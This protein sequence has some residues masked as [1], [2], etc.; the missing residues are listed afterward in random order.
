[1]GILHKDLTR[2]SRDA[3]K[4]RKEILSITDN[5]VSAQTS[6]DLIARFFQWH[7]WNEMYVAWESNNEA[8]IWWHERRVRE[9]IKI[10]LFGEKLLE[11]KLRDIN[12]M[13][14][15][16]QIENL[17]KWFSEKYS[18]KN[19]SLPATKKSIFSKCKPP[20]YSSFPRARFREGVAM[21][22]NDTQMICK[23]LG[24]H[25]IDSLERPGCVVYCKQFE[26][27]D[28]LRVFSSKE[29]KAKILSDGV[30][31]PGNVNAESLPMSLS[32]N[33]NSPYSVDE[34]LRYYVAQNVA[35]D[36]NS[37]YEGKHLR[38][39]VDVV[40]LM[41]EEK[42]QAALCLP[43]LETIFS[44]SKQS[45]LNEL[46]SKAKELVDF[47][48]PTEREV[49]DAE[50]GVFKSRAIE[51]WQYLAMQ[52]SSVVNK[53]QKIYDIGR[54]NIGDIERP[55]QGEL[56]LIIIPGDCIVEL[57]LSSMITK[58]LMNKF[59]DKMVAHSEDDI[60][61]FGP[62]S[63]RE[64]SI[65]T[66]EKKV[67]DFPKFNSAQANLVLYGPNVEGFITVE[68]KITISGDNYFVEDCEGY[69]EQ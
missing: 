14:G 68:T 9:K 25:F 46:K 67:F 6:L 31:L 56:L 11:K 49:V 53:S 37:P 18:P 8:H 40:I 38:N 2:L 54:G 29:Y 60:W 23:H 65:L 61:I 64:Q 52:I 34:L 63:A 50:N 41:K 30:L 21:I 22:S 42:K 51:Q 45:K 57:T 16:S 36:S 17:T 59:S 66:N 19:F 43:T 15:E 13:L 10:L 69:S 5:N 7:N 12:L 20:C 58:S 33:K 48:L 39:L 27:M 26:A 28:F 55:K 1:M 44:L 35:M 32:T 62:S 3:K 4:L 47:L 24:E